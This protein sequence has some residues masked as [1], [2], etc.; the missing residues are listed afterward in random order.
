MWN[1]QYPE[2]SNMNENKSKILVID[3]DARNVRLLEAMLLA[4][5][6]ETWMAPSGEDALTLVK[7]KLPDLIL[8]DVMMP[9]MNGFEVTEKLKSSASTRM[10]P[11]IMI[12]ALQDR[13]S[14]L[15]ALQAGADEFLSKPVDR[16]ELSLRV[17]NL[18][19]L[20]ECRRRM[21]Q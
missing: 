21:M 7:E 12:T 10:I 5:G 18:L 9:G 2:N 19:L 1:M 8:L 6:Y 14:R 17:R 15:Y 13:E 4:E 16:A 11:I 3:D 20:Q